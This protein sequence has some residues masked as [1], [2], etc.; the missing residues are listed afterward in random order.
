M[1]WHIY[2]LQTE[3][4]RSYATHPIV[5]YHFYV[6][7]LAREGKLGSITIHTRHLKVPT[8][9]YHIG[10]IHPTDPLGH[11]DG[12]LRLFALQMVPVA[13]IMASML[14]STCTTISILCKL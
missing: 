13:N 5:G 8:S 11:G 6:L 4:E 9:G 7:L 12:I 1:R 3:S 14:L 10:Q 2:A